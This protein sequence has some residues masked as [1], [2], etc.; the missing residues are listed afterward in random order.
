MS[1]TTANLGLFKYDTSADRDTA[2]SINQALN[3]NWDV[4]DNKVGDIEST[5]SGL[6]PSD[7]VSK[8]GDTMTGNLVIDKQGPAINFKNQ[9]ITK[10]TT[11]S[12]EYIE[13]LNFY[14]KNGTDAS[15]RMGRVFS[16]YTTTPT[17]Y[18]ALQAYQ[19]VSGSTLSTAIRVYYPKSGDPYTYAPP[20]DNTNSILTTTGIYKGQNG[21]LKLGNDIII[22]WGH[23]D[24]TSTSVVF[25]TAFSSAVYS[26]ATAA[27]YNSS[28]NGC[29][30]QNVKTGTLTKTGFEWIAKVSSLSPRYI[31][32]GK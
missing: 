28:Y 11:P 8:T 24:G 27:T 30:Y 23:S 14:D 31:V 5:I 22:Q 1:T 7:K 13:S 29:G 32:I 25:P 3:N 2:F 10:G 21:Y 20:S 18:T 19:P 16:S 4:I 9:Y 26:F 12:T 15:N 6:D 17:C